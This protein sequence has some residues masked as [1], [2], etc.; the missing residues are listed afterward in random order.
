[1]IIYLPC[2]DPCVL[3]VVLFSVLFRLQLSVVRPNRSQVV[4]IE[5]PCISVS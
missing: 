3:F 5:I 1:M 4:R 2:F